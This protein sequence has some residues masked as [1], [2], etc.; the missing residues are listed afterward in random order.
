MKAMLWIYLS[1]YRNC[2]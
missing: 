2:K 1:K